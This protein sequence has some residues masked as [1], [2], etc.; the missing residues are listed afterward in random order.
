MRVTLGGGERSIA[1]PVP[2]RMRDAR[3]RSGGF[4]KSYR[5]HSPVSG[6]ATSRAFVGLPPATHGFLSRSA[7]PA[8]S[9][10]CRLVQNRQ[11]S[12]RF[13][14]SSLV[15]A[16]CADLQPNL[17]LRSGTVIDEVPACR[18]QNGGARPRC[19]SPDFAHA[20]TASQTHSP[21]ARVPR[22]TTAPRRAVTHALLATPFHSRVLCAALRS[23]SVSTPCHDACA[24]PLAA[25]SRL[26]ERDG[27]PDLW[28]CSDH[29]A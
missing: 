19:S 28:Q 9:L 6:T 7:L 17:Q 22:H 10:R 18:A 11:N 4:V 14:G 24:A 5:V 27:D 29:R 20:T 15:I 21:L 1:L 12:R 23:P 2:A 8:N 16:R 3:A 13:V 25:V 26:C